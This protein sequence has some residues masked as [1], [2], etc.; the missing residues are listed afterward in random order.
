MNIA[1]FG[2]PGSGKGTQGNLIAQKF[3]YIHL[4]SGEIL[5]GEIAANSAWGIEAEKY[6]SK[7]MLVPDDLI[8]NILE[9][10]IDE[11]KSA[12]GMIF[13]GFPR[14][15]VQAEELE[16]ML[17]KHGKKINVMIEVYVDEKTLFNRLVLRGKN[18]GRSDDTPETIYKRLAVYH[19]Q[20]APVMEFYKRTNRYQSVDNNSSVEECFEQICKLVRKLIS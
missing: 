15:I 9:I 13:D 1:L 3:G 19:E 20:T 16:T 5:R 6:I 18:S 8:I 7:G 12:K 10:K 2:A 17:G 11:N 14:T 4:S